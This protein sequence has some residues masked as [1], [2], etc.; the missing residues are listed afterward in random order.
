MEMEEMERPR[1]ALGTWT[2]TADL[3]DTGTP[4]GL[5][6]QSDA[7]SADQ[8]SQMPI[9]TPDREALGLRGWLLVASGRSRSNGT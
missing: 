6:D 1:H 5:L 8:P 7:P 4:P 2:G 3:E 9:G